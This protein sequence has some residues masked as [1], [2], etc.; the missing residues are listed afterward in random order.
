MTVGKKENVLVRGVHIELWR[1]LHYLEKQ[2]GKE[3]CAPQGST[4]MPAGGPMDHSYNITPDL[5]GHRL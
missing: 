4:R 3:V 5:G 2:R 1:M